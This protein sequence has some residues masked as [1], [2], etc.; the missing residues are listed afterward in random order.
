MLLSKSRQFIFI[1]VPKVAGRSIQEALRNY[2]DWP[3]DYIVVTRMLRM[4][5]AR[6]SQ[7]LIA[8]GFI[9]DARDSIPSYVYYDHVR[10]WQLRDYLDQ[11]YSSYFSFAFVR[12][13]WDWNVSQYNYITNN[14]KNAAHRTVKELTFEEYLEWWAFART[15]QQ[16]QFIRNKER[17]I[18]VDFVGRYETIDIDF[19][20]V[21]QRLGI[22]AALP[23]LNRTAHKDYRAYYTKKSIERVEQIHSDDVDLFGYSF[24]GFLGEIS[25]KIDLAGRKGEET[26]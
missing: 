25:P 10:A 3:A 5:P 2:A 21:C 8:R 22:K 16:S 14:P 9:G 1:H 13:P 6:F 23:H 4:L 12:N 17:N 11:S 19:N 15:F 26:S 7:A 18:I 24:D 20:Y